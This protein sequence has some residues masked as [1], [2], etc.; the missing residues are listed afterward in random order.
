MRSLR[1][2]QSKSPVI[3][4]CLFQ[5]LI[6]IKIII[7]IRAQ[8]EFCIDVTGHLFFKIFSFFFQPLYLNGLLCFT[9]DISFLI[10]SLNDALPANNMEFPEQ[11]VL[12]SDTAATYL[13]G[14]QNSTITNYYFDLS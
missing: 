10:Q 6:I 1:K 4:S 14:N 2:E 13:D 9:S 7:N 3:A 8:N 11:A 5:L 12:S